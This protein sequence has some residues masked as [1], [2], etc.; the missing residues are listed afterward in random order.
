MMARRGKNNWVLILFILIGLV[1]GGI[2]GEIA[3]EID[4][5]WWLGYGKQF[6]FTQPVTLDLNILRLSLSV[7]V[8]INIASIIG[9][10]LA[11]VVY[12]KV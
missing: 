7:L 3:S 4:S 10:A 12:R 11:L 9:M 5:L 2:I 1:I 6:G 8:K